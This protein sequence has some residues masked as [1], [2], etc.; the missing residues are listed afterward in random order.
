MSER[1]GRLGKL[2]AAGRCRAVGAS[3]TLRWVPGSFLHPH[4]PFIGTLS[5]AAGTVVDCGGQGPCPEGMWDVRGTGR[6][7]EGCRQLAEV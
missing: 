3:G 2:V 7:G 6:V 5:W 1:G 4:L